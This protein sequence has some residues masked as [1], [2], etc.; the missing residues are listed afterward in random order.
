MSGDQKE[1]AGTGASRHAAEHARSG[2][3][4]Q[5][6]GTTE[7]STESECGMSRD[8]KEGAGTGASR[9]AGEHERSGGDIQQS[10]TIY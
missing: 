10:G 6:S 9:D 1:G 5:Q 4:I 8:Q 3:D 7:R 2:G